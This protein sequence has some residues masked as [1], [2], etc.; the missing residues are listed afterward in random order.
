MQVTV[1]VPLTSCLFRQGVDLSELAVWVVSE[2]AIPNIH[3]E[4]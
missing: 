2:V 4:L 1:K 3:Q